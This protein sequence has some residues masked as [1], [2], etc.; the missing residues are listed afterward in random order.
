MNL[1]EFLERVVKQHSYTGKKIEFVNHALSPVIMPLQPLNLNRCISNIISNACRYGDQVI[2][3]LY[4]EN[5]SAHILI[6]DNGPGVPEKQYEEVFKP[7]VRLDSARSA[8]TGGAG[9]GLS[10]A[11]DVVLAHGGKINLGKS[12]KLGGLKVSVRLPM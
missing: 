12:E 10:V 2:V 5:K 9:L 4:T 7:F 8:D 11:M 3:T 1:N 6:E